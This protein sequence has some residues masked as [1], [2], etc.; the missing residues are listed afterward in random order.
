MLTRPR[1]QVAATLA[2]AL[3]TIAP[4]AYVAHSAYRVRQPSHLRDVEA[5]IGRRLGV[6]VRVDHASH[7][8]PDVDVFRGVSLRLDHAG[9]AEFARADILRVTRENTETTLRIDRLHLRGDGAEDALEQVISMMRR[10][11]TSDAERIGL[12]AEECTLE[13]ATGTETIHELAAILQID[14]ATPTLNASYLILDPGRRSRTRCELVVR[15]QTVAGAS[16]TTVNVKTMDGRVPA[17]VLVPFFDVNSWLGAS[18]SL[19]GSLTLTRRDRQGWE[20][21]FQ[22]EL[23]DADLASVVGRRFAG[24]RLSGLARIAID[25]CR[26][27]QRPVEQ[28]PGWVE[29]KG[30]LTAGPGSI[31]VGLLRALESRMRFRLPASFEEKRSDIDFQALG[32]RF[33]MNAD[34]ELS[35]AGGLGGEF[36]PDAVLVQGLRAL[37]LARAPEG[38]ANVRGLLNTL[39]PSTPEALAP[40]VPEAHALQWLPLPPHRPGSV[41]AN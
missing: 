8:R 19:E 32:L 16:V 13:T 11:A 34:G 5:E 30:T 36:A 38:T 6:L 23:S 25:S 37:P 10:L 27:A 1:R 22:G 39:L 24:H 20:A 41:S 26:W 33:A 21:S 31:S 7:P 18:A 9:H 2:L 3:L 4:T 29:A 40:A 17:Q 12:V 14:R 28:G 35:L 15:R